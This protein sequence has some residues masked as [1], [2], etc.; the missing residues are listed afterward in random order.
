MGPPGAAGGLGAVGAKGEAVSEG[1][2]LFRNYYITSLTIG[3][4]VF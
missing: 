1:V 4:S 2:L 3:R